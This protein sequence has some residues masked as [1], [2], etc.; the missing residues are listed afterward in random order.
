M[1]RNGHLHA[2]LIGI[3]TVLSLASLGLAQETTGSS[4]KCSKHRYTLASLAGNYSVTGVFGPHAGGYVGTTDIDARGAITN[5][6]GVVVDPALP[7]PPLELSTTG[8]SA[9]NPDGTG[10]FTESVTIAGSASNVTYHFN[11]VI[12]EARLR[13]DELIATRIVLVQQESSPL[14]NGPIFASFIYTRRP[15]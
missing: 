13:G 10:L 1:S 9:I 2:K 4:Q 5:D 15:E 7:G 14:P 12:A 6:I 11:F 3:F 8:E